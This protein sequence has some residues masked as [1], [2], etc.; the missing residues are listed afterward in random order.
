SSWLW[1]GAAASV[2][3]AA[4]TGRRRSLRT[5]CRFVTI[6][7]THPFHPHGP[8]VATL[9]REVEHVVR[10]HHYLHAAPVG[11]VGVKDLARVAL[12]E[13]ADAGPFLRC[14]RPH[15]VI[16]VELALG[17]FLWREADAEVA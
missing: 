4:R 14:E 16:V 17:H 12:V 2:R 3:L 15:A 10:T 8:F 7:V 13:R 9:G 5:W 1:S 11:R 6:V